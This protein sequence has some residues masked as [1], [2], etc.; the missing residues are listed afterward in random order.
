MMTKQRIRVS[1]MKDITEKLHTTC[2]SEVIV[3]YC[4][5]RNRALKNDGGYSICGVT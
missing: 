2:E 5:Y 1:V 3:I 4:M